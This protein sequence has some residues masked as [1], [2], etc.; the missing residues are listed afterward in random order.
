M[1]RDYVS[2]ES[3]SHKVINI[4]ACL[5]SQ[6]IGLGVIL[7]VKFRPYDQMD[8]FLIDPVWPIVVKNLNVI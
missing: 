2:L 6:I 3:H 8:Y 7:K 5:S 1:I 4:S